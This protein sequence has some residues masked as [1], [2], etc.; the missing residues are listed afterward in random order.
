VKPHFCFAA[1][2]L[3]FV[4]QY[5]CRQ[6]TPAENY[7]NSRACFA[8]VSAN[9]E[10]VPAAR[11]RQAGVPRSALRAVADDTMSAAYD[12]GKLAGMTPE[13]IFHDLE[14]AKSSYLRA[15]SVTIAPAGVRRFHAL[16]AAVNTCLADYYGRPND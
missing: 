2:S 8:A 12:A 11:L 14:H 3:L 10:R 1:A 5:S 16:G 7:A 4:P 13:A 15:H 6:P 9:L